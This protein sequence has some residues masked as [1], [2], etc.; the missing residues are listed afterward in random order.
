MRKFTAKT[1]NLNNL[2]FLLVFFL[3]FTSQSQATNVCEPELIMQ[4]PGGTPIFDCTN[5][6]TIVCD[7]IYANKQ[8]YNLK[9]WYFYKNCVIGYTTNTYFIFNEENESFLQYKSIGAW[10]REIEKLNLTPKYYSCWLS[11]K[12]SSKGLQWFKNVLKI[13]ITII[14]LLQLTVVIVLI[15]NK[16][17]EM[18]LGVLLTNLIVSLIFAGIYFLLTNQLSF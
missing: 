18:V 16:K 11:V 15:Y 12:S 8:L 1:Q 2:K 9:K 3:G 14:F 6:T 10:K 7:S 13:P 5:C 4:A 17:K